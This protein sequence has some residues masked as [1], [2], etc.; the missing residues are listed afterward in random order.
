MLKSRSFYVGWYEHSFIK[1][2]HLYI[3]GKTEGHLILA[4]LS[5][6]KYDTH[7]FT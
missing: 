6:Y 4:D 3:T 5:L 7:D 2:S 1:Q